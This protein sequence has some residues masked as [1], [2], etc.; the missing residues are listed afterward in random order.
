MYLYVRHFSPAARLSYAVF[1]MGF[2]GLMVLIF[3][4]MGLARAAEAGL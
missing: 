4:G 3:V 2:F 1:A